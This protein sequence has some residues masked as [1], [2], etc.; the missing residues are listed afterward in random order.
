M[1]EIC[2]II[3]AAGVM[4]FGSERATGT[5]APGRRHRNTGI[6]DPYL[7]S[8]CHVKGGTWLN[9]HW[10]DRRWRRFARRSSRLRKN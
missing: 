3:G 2:G 10:N 1:P 4:R 7:S 9:G 5:C 6:L 8:Q